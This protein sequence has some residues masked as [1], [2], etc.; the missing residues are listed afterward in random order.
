M[1]EDEG[2]GWEGCNRIQRESVR[3]MDVSIGLQ[4]QV[5]NDRRGVAGG[6]Q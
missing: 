6:T 2:V 5:P 1:D 4:S 3:T